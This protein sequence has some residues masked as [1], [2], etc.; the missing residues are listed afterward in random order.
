[1]PKFD[2]VRDALDSPTVEFKPFAPFHTTHIPPPQH[3]QHVQLPPEPLPTPYAPKR[4]SAPGSIMQPLTQADLQRFLHPP[5]R[6]R[7]PG[8]GRTAVE[9]IYER[10]GL[11][12]ILRGESHAA[13]STSKRRRDEGDLDDAPTAKRT[14]D[15]AD[16]MN[17]YN[18][19]ANVSVVDREDSPI[20]GL[21]NFN[22]WVKSVLIAK[23]AR[24]SIVP[25][26]GRVLDMGCGKGGD[27]NKWQKAQVAEYV[28]LDNAAVSIDQARGRFGN[29][30]A[31]RGRF[32]AKFFH[33]DCFV[34][35]VEA[36]APPECFSSLFDVV[37]M[38]FCMHY[39]FESE[40]QARMMLRNVTKHLKPGGVFLG[41]IPNDGQLLERLEALPPGTPDQE[42]TW[43]NSV[44]GIQFFNKEFSTYGQ[45]Y[46]FYLKDA[47]NN[48][49]EFVVHWENFEKL[50]HSYG[51]ELL[52]RRE[53]HDVFEDER[54]DPEFRSL[55]SKM[56]VVD[57][58]NE[59]HIDQDQWEA[60]NVYV[61]FAFQ[62]TDHP[63]PDY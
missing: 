16:V 9:A 44:Y 39:A 57:E 56:K 13:A 18:Q 37:S 61:A 23:F 43:G 20:I 15:T 40:P 17:H 47:V 22:N 35:R 10:Q 41:T 11:L 29:M 4:R 58:A 59:S 7:P 53:F 21:K 30:R 28:G 42:L 60:I 31:N 3:I 54:E 52:Y 8:T 45:R 1:M 2:P 32:R 19:R 6:L 46:M 55:L 62:R 48:V 26:R 12:H 14:R 63:C 24:E 51:L 5:N 34:E 49:P 33:V 50:A 38:Q 27:L 36:I 25:G